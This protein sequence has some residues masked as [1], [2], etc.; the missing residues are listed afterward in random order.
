MEKVLTAILSLFG[1]QVLI[2]LSS[3]LGMAIG[4]LSFWAPEKSIGLYQRVMQC[5]NW[6]VEPIDW[7]HEIRSTRLWGLL[8]MALS[9][10]AGILILLK[11]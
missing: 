2:G 8:L 4:A 1:L 9:L 5:L 7:K 11:P 3:L 6:R 10:V